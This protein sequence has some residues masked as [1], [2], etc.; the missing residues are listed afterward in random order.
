MKEYRINW[1]NFMNCAYRAFSKVRKGRMTA[2]TDKFIKA[3]VSELVPSECRFNIAEALYL[4]Q[5]RRQL[6]YC[7]ER[8]ANNQRGSNSKHSLWLPLLTEKRGGEIRPKF[9]KNPRQFGNAKQKGKILR[10]LNR[11]TLSS[12]SQNTSESEHQALRLLQTIKGHVLQLSA[13]LNGLEKR[14]GHQ[15]F[16]NRRDC[17]K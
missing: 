13:S 6:M 9:A 14:H 8:T 17:A 4:D 15:S 16:R 10:E 7:A 2:P 11:V 5:A 12:Y 1:N 3:I